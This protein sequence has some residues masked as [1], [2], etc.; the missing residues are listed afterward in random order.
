MQEITEFLFIIDY[1]SESA[2]SI[3]TALEKATTKYG[4][5]LQKENVSVRSIFAVRK[6]VQ[7]K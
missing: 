5:E 1:K 3:I 7:R 6:A 2:E 4:F